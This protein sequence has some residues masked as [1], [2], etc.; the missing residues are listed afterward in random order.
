[1]TFDFAQL[2]AHA[3]KTRD[4]EAGAIIGSGTISNKQGG[5]WGPNIDNHVGYCCLAGLRM[6]E[7]IEQDSRPRPS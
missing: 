6:Y 2:I 3:D 4:L 5:L 7:T 1:M